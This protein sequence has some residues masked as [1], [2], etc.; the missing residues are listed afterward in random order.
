MLGS[1]EKRDEDPKCV[2][3]LGKRRDGTWDLVVHYRI[4]VS[5][6]HQTI[7]FVK[8]RIGFV[9]FTVSGG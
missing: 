2:L 9:L 4:N 6:I 5:F 3:T 7:T 8:A 1:R